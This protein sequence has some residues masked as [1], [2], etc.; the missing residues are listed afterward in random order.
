[1]VGSTTD[2][3]DRYN[4]SNSQSLQSQVPDMLHYRHQPILLITFLFYILFY[5]N[6]SQH[7]QISD[8]NMVILHFLNQ[9]KGCSRSVVGMVGFQL[10]LVELCN[11]VECRRA[12]DIKRLQVTG[13]KVSWDPC[14]IEL[15]D[16]GDRLGDKLNFKRNNFLRR[17]VVDIT[18]VPCPTHILIP[19]VHLLLS[20]ELDQ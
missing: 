10:E 18:V 6:V 13:L 20:A 12:S 1:M 7:L 17:I 4:F 16:R 15:L 3:R 11:L 5:T 8:C 14:G 9:S 19:W 2:K